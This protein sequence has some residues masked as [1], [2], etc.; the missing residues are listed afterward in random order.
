M[1]IIMNVQKCI[2]CHK[3]PLIFLQFIWDW[4]CPLYLQ[5]QIIIK[6][7]Y[8]QLIILIFFTEKIT[9]YNIFWSSF[10]AVHLRFSHLAAHKH[11]HYSNICP[12]LLFRHFLTVRIECDGKSIIIIL[13]V[14]FTFSF[15]FFHFAWIT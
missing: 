5:Q 12:C 4:L 11:D 13:L 10:S 14:I 7:Q 6:R 2:P 1:P 3:L 15:Y 8:F 9:I